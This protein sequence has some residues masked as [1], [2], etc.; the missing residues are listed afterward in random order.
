MCN[1][2]VCCGEVRR[3]V[4]LCVVIYLGMVCSLMWFDAIRCRDVCTLLLLL[5]RS[6]LG[7]LCRWLC[8]WAAALRDARE[9]GRCEVGGE[10]RGRGGGREGGK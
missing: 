4:M 1:G 10:V 6:F 2:V 5:L 3:D 8:S 9:A 7:G